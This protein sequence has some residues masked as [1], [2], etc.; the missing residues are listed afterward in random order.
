MNGTRAVYA[1]IQV[2]CGIHGEANITMSC[3][4]FYLPA[5]VAMYSE[6]PERELGGNHMKKSRIM[7]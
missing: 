1:I 6:N 4:V 3:L 5:F 2:Q 7:N